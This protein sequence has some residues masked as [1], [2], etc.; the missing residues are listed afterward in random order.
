MSSACI[1]NSNYIFIRQ[2]FSAS[3]Q[4]TDLCFD[5]RVKLP[6]AHRSTTYS[7]SSH[8]HFLLLNI[9]QEAVIINFYSLCFDPTGF[10][11]QSTVSV[12]KALST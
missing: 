8:G 4:L 5:L 3:K 11:P 9:Q 10:E 2:V 7:E 6:L 1:G 12:A